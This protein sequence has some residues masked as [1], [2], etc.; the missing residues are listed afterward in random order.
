M[1]EPRPRVSV[2]RAVDRIMQLVRPGSRRPLASE[3]GTFLV[4]CRF[5]GDAVTI[6]ITNEDGRVRVTATH[7]VPLCPEFAR[8]YEEPW[9]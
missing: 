8:I 9:P 1:P 7:D 5:C 3:P 2:Q 6:A 4:G